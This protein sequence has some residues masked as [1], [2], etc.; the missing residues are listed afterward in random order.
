MQLKLS[1]KC[2]RAYP[3][4][5]AAL[6]SRETASF[7]SAV[8]PFILLYETHSGVD[9]LASLMRAPPQGRSV[10]LWLPRLDGG[11][12]VRGAA[13]AAWRN[14]FLVHE[15]P[16]SNGSIHAHP[17]VFAG[18]ALTATAARAA[19][20]SRLLLLANSES[21]SPGNDMTTARG[22]RVVV[23]SRRNRVKRALSQ[24]AGGRNRLSTAAAIDGS[25]GSRVDKGQLRRLLEGE[26]T[27]SLTA[28][29][30]ESRSLAAAAA[31][32]PLPAGTS[33]DQALWL[34]YEDLLYE[35]QRSVQR[36]WA[37]LG[38]R[39]ED[40]KKY[41]AAAF[42]AAP[43]AKRTSNDLCSA[44]ANYHEAC[45]ALLRSR[46]AADL[47][48]SN[49]ASWCR[50]R[51]PHVGLVL[52]GSHHKTGTVLLMK[53]LLTFSAAVGLPFH[54]PQWS[55]CLALQRREPG[56]CFDEHASFGRLYRTLL[57]PSSAGALVRARLVH[58]VREPLEVCV[59]SYQYHLHSTEAP[60]PKPLKP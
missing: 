20:L 12:Q 55:G 51:S 57:D 19:N 40:A 18:L 22:V 26:G 39:S 10:S 8:R 9:W 44:I 21:V 4:G 45:V 58:V 11:S 43:P 25:G 30:C 54:K 6:H 24:L 59:S 15:A 37:H 60:P 29:L 47:G 16:H 1:A 31:S 49:R 48:A 32:R 34:D 13:I 28:V 56:V 53:V 50:C 36:L 14:A 33:T 23:L 52:G 2:E 27:R 7:D 38:V 42:S 35:P 41:A 3:P 17:L 5:P 46:W